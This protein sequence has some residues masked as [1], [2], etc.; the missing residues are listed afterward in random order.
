MGDFWLF[1]FYVLVG[2]FTIILSWNRNKTYGRKGRKRK[3]KDKET[4]L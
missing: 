4:Y 1:Q 2:V 3:K